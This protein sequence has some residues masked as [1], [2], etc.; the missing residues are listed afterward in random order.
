MKNLSSDDF[1][2]YLQKGIASDIFKAQYHYFIFR[3]IGENHNAITNLCEEQDQKMFGYIQNAANYDSIL[4]LSRVFD[5]PNRRY[6]V[7]C[8][9]SA[10]KNAEITESLYF[11]LTLEE[12]FED[13][14]YPHTPLVQI[15]ELTGIDLDKVLYRNSAELCYYLLM[16]LDD[17]SQRSRINQIKTVRDKFIAHNEIQSE[18]LS[19]DQFWDEYGYLLTLSRLYLSL[20]GELFANTALDVT[21]NPLNDGVSFQTMSNANWLFV[22][23]EKLLSKE[24]IKQWW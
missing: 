16:V 4:S 17:G 21:G 5:R 22:K 9:M 19:I 18:I 6:N 14:H 24:Q 20:L 3:T 15:A 2:E 7:S 11:P 12:E 10:I 1:G 23:L 8:L 13:A